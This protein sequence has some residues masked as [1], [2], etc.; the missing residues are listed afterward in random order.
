MKKVLWVLLVVVLLTASNGV[1]YY[2]W[3]GKTVKAEKVAN[4]TIAMLQATIDSIGTFDDVYTVVGHV[5]AGSEITAEQITEMSMPTAD[6]TEAYVTDPQSIIGQLYKVDLDNGTPI[7]TDMIMS[8]EIKDS[9]R[10]VDILVDRWTVGLAVGDYV[11]YR[12]TLPYGDD[13]IVLPHLRVEAVGTQTIKVWMTEDQW[14]TYIGSRIDCALQS[15]FGATTYLQRYVEPGVQVAA[16]PYYAVPNNIKA[17]MVADPNII[18]LAALNDSSKLR[19][20][21]DK[22]LSQLVTENDTKDKELSELRTG[23]EDFNAAVNADKTS[24]GQGGDE[25]ISSSELYGEDPNDVFV[26]E[27]EEVVE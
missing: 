16:T 7:T 14:H 22:V 8:K 5:K 20:G 25:Y 6:V 2:L 24:A 3:H 12:L 11:D 23:H 1:Q 19:K 26:Y 15:E 9:T 21:I 17:I 27:E 13:Y 4:E 10:D 18:D